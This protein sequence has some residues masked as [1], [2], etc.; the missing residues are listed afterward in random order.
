MYLVIILTKLG[1]FVHPHV[2]VGPLVCTN[3]DYWIRG[4]GLESFMVK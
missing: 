1:I 3:F 4:V 2:Y